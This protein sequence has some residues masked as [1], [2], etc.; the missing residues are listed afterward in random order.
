MTAAI[1]H[2]ASKTPSVK[3]VVITSS[4]VA[5]RDSSPP[6]SRAAS[7]D[8]RLEMPPGPPYENQNMRYTASKIASLKAVD[9]FME[10]E[11]PAFTVVN[12][13][14]GFV[15][16]RQELATS[17][18]DLLSSSNRALLIPVTG[19]ILPYAGTGRFVS[20]TVSLEDVVGL[21]LGCLVSEKLKKG[22]NEWSFA[23]AG[24]EGGDY[25]DIA[26]IAGRLFPDAVRAGRLRFAREEERM[27]TG[28]VQIYK[29]DI[30][31]VEEVLGRKLKGLEEQVREVVGQH[32]EL[33]G[34]SFMH[35]TD[36]Y[37]FVL[38]KYVLIKIDEA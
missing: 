12:I 9:D 16:G 30:K 19:G 27:K 21:H 18:T 14:P 13:M 24:M 3:R 35:T 33:L 34:N 20:P 17:S 38:L 15:V 22:R 11:K 26:G 10:K 7:G 2:A 8:N 23:I 31:G 1:L 4:M 28:K 29:V 36:G 25:E 37:P 32:L 5:I 6:G